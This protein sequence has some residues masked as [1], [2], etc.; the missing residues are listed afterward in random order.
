V[1]EVQLCSIYRQ[2][3][4]K[5]GGCGDSRE[6]REGLDLGQPNLDQFRERIYILYVYVLIVRGVNTGYTYSSPFKY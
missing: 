3:K 1:R 6:S 4:D 5:Y 2:D